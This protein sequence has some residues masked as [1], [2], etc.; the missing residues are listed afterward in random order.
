MPGLVAGRVVPLDRDDQDVISRAGI[1]QRFR[2]GRRGFASGGNQDDRQHRACDKSLHHPHYDSYSLRYRK[3][4]AVYAPSRPACD[5]FLGVS[6]RLPGRFGTQ[7]LSQAGTRYTK[8][9]S[10]M[11]FIT[12]SIGNLLATT[13]LAATPAGWQMGFAI[14]V[15]VIVA[16]I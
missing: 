3:P 16:V 15:G 6:L 1:R 7:H 5:T 13:G 4:I 14:T 10:N 2:R 9:H 8:E 12:H 11:L